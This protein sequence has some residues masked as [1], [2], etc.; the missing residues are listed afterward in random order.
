[1]H[2]ARTEGHVVSVTIDVLF[3]DDKER[4]LATAALA[5][6]GFRQS[7]GA[8]MYT[9]TVRIELAPGPAA[10][11]AGIHV[12]ARRHI[13]AIAKRPVAIRVVD[14]PALAPRLDQLLN[15]TFERTAGHPTAECWPELIAY[16]RRHP[17]LIRLVSLVRTD[18]EGP[19]SLLAFALGINHGDHV[20][21]ATA[22][23]TRPADL[24]IPLGYALAWDLVEWAHRMGVWW[25]NFGGI[26]ARLRPDDPR[27]GIHQFKLMFSDNIVEVRREWFYVA[28][29]LRAAWLTATACWQRW[30][31]G[32]ARAL[33]PLARRCCRTRPASGR[34]G[35]LVRRS[36]ARTAR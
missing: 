2:A 25:F 36:S 15:E 17:E 11:F 19:E 23:S 20:E 5:R 32:A 8:R 34:A 30:L 7:G 28:M 24:R 9:H 18:R 4:D 10:L 27:H 14:D 3:E 22:G 12:T 6:L 35:Q 16:G 33:G 21:Y 1:M 31:N 29:P 26:T 13:R